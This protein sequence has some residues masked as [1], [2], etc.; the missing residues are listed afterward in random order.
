MGKFST[1]VLVAASAYVAS[2]AVNGGKYAYL[3][4]KGGDY[5]A[6][7]FNA[8]GYNVWG[9]NRDMQDKWGRDITDPL[10]GLVEPVPQF[11]EP[12]GE[13]EDDKEEVEV[14]EVDLKGD[15]D[16]DDYQF[17]QEA[18]S[19]PHP[20][21]SLPFPPVVI[22]TPYFTP[23]WNDRPEASNTPHFCDD[24]GY[25]EFV[26]G[27][28]LD[29]EMA[30]WYLFDVSSLLSLS[31]DLF[32][33]ENMY[34]SNG[35]EASGSE[36]QT[37]ILVEF[38][39]AKDVD[40][41]ASTAA[42]MPTILSGAGLLTDEVIVQSGMNWDFFLT[43]CRAAK[44]SKAYVKDGKCLPCPPSPGC[45][46][47]NST[48]STDGVPSCQLG[49]HDSCSVGYAKTSILSPVCQPCA[50]FYPEDDKGDGCPANLRQ[51]TVETPIS[52][53]LAAENGT[54]ASAVCLLNVDGSGLS[55]SCNAGFGPTEAKLAGSSGYFAGFSGGVLNDDLVCAPCSES[56]NYKENCNDEVVS[57]Y[58][59]IVD[60]ETVTPLSFNECL[61][62]CCAD[63]FANSGSSIASECIAV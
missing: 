7:G 46:E 13:D 42:D 33:V 53:G 28:S 12:E 44:E 48:C 43:N 59:D 31:Q 36:F 3:A 32:H 8:E 57:A 15:D 58:C 45:P 62:G 56:V 14:V 35:T 29:Y 41:V 19:R 9:F 23:L 18:P 25:V 16:D 54:F 26:V 10:A 51:C 30:A 6:D 63:D 40:K 52:S 47:A 34:V 4:I 20:Q 22:N 60:Y 24:G 27:V 2:A 17:H 50:F 11:I 38:C 21:E 49:P 5:D 39:K 37:H 61:N 55:F 1:V